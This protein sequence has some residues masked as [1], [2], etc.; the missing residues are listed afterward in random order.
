[1]GE[2]CVRNA[3]VGGSTPLRSTEKA[4]F[5]NTADK[6]FSLEFMGFWRIA[7]GGVRSSALSDETTANDTVCPPLPEFGANAGA[8]FVTACLESVTASRPSVPVARIVWRSVDG[9]G[10]RSRDGSES[11]APYTSSNFGSV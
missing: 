10:L 6:A 11:N 9:E 4:L 3:E 5:A 8:N 7:L 2:R 1:M